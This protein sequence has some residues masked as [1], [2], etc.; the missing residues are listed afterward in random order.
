MY[1]M[2]NIWFNSD[3]NSSL[4]FDSNVVLYLVMLFGYNSVCKQINCVYFLCMGTF[5][6]F[7]FCRVF[8]LYQ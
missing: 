2:Y 4:S 8:I 6:K 1:Q 3:M 7:L 5:G